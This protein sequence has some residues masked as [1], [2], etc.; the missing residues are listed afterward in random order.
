MNPQAPFQDEVDDWLSFM[1]SL[2]MLLTLL[3]GVA[4]LA[5]DSASVQMN[6]M[7]K[8]HL[9]KVLVA[10]N[11]LALIGL[12][13]SIVCLHP[14]VRL[15]MKRRGRGR[16]GVSAAAQK[17]GATTVTPMVTQKQA[18][19]GPNEGSGRMKEDVQEIRTWKAD[20]REGKS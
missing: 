20:G 10:I 16:G 5:N 6:D 11:S 1:T 2:Q 18:A 17:T 12:L 4:L 14:K 9:D 3:G 7:Q 13:L 15:M 19:T 8:S